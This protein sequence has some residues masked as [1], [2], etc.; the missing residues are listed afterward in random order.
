MLIKPNMV[1]LILGWLVVMAVVICVVVWSG[2][3]QAIKQP[4]IP[5]QPRGE[6]LPTFN[7]APQIDGAASTTTLPAP[8][9]VVPPHY[10]NKTCY[11]NLG[12]Q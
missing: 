5:I 2:Y 9:N 7:Y 10:Q 8:T 12:C 4:Y 6:L 3:M 1:D 11:T